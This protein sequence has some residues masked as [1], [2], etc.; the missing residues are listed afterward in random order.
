MSCDEMNR[1]EERLSEAQYAHTTNLSHTHIN[2]K[3]E[4]GER[5]EKKT[6]QTIKERT[7]TQFLD[8]MGRGDSKMESKKN[9]RRNERV[10]NKHKY[11]TTK[12]V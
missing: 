1:G 8:G 9:E 6:D 2:A 5:K 3:G 11:N 12:Q 7:Q 4:K 10:A